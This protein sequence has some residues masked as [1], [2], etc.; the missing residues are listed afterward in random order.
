M[1]VLYYEKKITTTKEQVMVPGQ[2]THNS[3]S[4]GEWDWLA[5]QPKQPKRRAPRY[6]REVVLASGG[7][8]QAP[9]SE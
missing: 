9:G 3:P 1:E 8:I 5:K 2:K 4:Q 7:D 6:I